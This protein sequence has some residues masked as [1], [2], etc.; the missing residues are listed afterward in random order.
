VSQERHSRRPSFTAA[1]DMGCNRIP[2]R[3]GASGE[4]TS[5]EPGSGLR[6]KKKSDTDPSL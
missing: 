2:V 5:A 4:S 6:A 3:V 1:A